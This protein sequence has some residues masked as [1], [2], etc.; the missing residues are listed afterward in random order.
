MNRRAFL[1]ASAGLGSTAALAG[2]L[3]ALGFERQSAWRDPP[4][5]EDRPDSVYYP[6]VVEGMSVYGTD[7][8]GRVGFALMHSFPHRFWTVTGTAQ[9]KV[10]VDAEDTVHLMATVW[11]TNSG[12]ILPVDPSIT[13]TDDDGATVGTTTLWPMLSPNMGFHYGDNVALPGSGT[14]DATLTVGPVG[15]TRTAPFG[16]A[17]DTGASTTIPFTFDPADT[18]NLEYRRLRDRAGDPGTVDLMSMDGVPEPVAPAESALPGTVL[19]APSVDGMEL[20]VSVVR[21]GARFGADGQPY[22]VVSPRTPYNRILLPRMAL[23]LTATDAS[24]ATRFDGALAPSL[25]PDLGAYYGAPVEGLAGG[26]TLTI[27]VDTPP[28]LARHDGYE[29]AFRAAG[30]TATVSYPTNGGTAP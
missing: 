1:T 5:A 7:S 25:D 3:G 9:T 24:G 6:A 12:A 26:E 10:V 15:I 18:Y 21:D 28:Q 2:C 11:D 30:G 17:F 22:V 4:L 8:S 29:T 20:A 23:S 19:G 16:D 13:I 27:T 14:Y